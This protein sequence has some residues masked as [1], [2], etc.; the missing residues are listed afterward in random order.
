[1]GLHK[2]LTGDDLHN[3]KSQSGAGDPNGSV[4]ASVIGELYWDTTNNNLYVAE[5]TDNSSWILATGAG[6]AVASVFGRTGAVVAVSGDYEA[7]EVTNAFDKLADDTDDITEGAT[8]K[9]FP[10]AP[11]D[12]SQYARKDGAWEAVSG[13]GGDVVGPASSVNNDIAVFDGTT[14]K[15]IK[16]GGNNISEVLDRANHT[17]TQTASTI[18]DFDTE[19]SNNT[20]V[21]ANT[22]HR[23][24]DGSNHTFI[25]QSVTTTAT[26][27]FDGVD[28]NNSRFNV[29]DDGNSSTA[30][31]IDFS[32]TSFHKSTLTDNVTYTFTAPFSG[33][34]DQVRL[35]MK[36]VQDITG[37]RDI[38]FPVN[39][40]WTEGEPT[41]TS[42][43]S[44]QT[45]LVTFIYDDED[46]EYIGQATSWYS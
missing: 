31:T 38:T 7:S 27:V 28:L 36:I 6:G 32:A 19:V 11:I 40:T 43:T 23:T 41:W 20:D 1:M 10:E 29:T 39:V 44:N 17:G 42:G 13:A 30:D 8:N 15:L 9:Y 37:G 25:D 24:S 46:D 12:G 16:N 2:D 18:S 45:I 35:Q 34:T 33:T 26:P 5:A 22:T 4:T 3:A 21:A 14:G